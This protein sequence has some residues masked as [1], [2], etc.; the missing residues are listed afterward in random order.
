MVI[1]PV[2]NLLCWLRVIGG[3]GAGKLMTTALLVFVLIGIWSVIDV[4]VT[5][6][7]AA[8]DKRNYDYSSWTAKD[9]REFQQAENDSS[10]WWSNF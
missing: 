9:E 3:D 5:A 4:I 6:R 1:R 10:A 7:N 8:Q 2:L